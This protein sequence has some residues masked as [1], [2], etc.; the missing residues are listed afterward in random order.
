[1][2]YEPAAIMA[3]A[4]IVMIHAQTIRPATPQRTPETPASQLQLNTL[5]TTASITARKVEE[6][7]NLLDTEDAVKY[8]PSVFLRKRNR[9]DAIEIA[10]N[11]LIGIL[12]HQQILHGVERITQ[13][14]LFR[15]DRS[16][17]TRVW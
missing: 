4:G 14:I 16:T 11:E 15:D 13:R 17:L 10:L 12:R 2:K 3:A 6:T 9:S 1:M 8:L 7:V 5:P